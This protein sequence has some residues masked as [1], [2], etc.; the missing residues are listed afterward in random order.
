M[1]I[2]YVMWKI[3]MRCDVQIYVNKLENFNKL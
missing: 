1:W 3:V 2:I